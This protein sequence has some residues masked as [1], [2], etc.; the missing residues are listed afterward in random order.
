M[1]NPVSQLAQ[2]ILLAAVAAAEANKA[3]IITK[4]QGVEGPLVDALF[5]DVEKTIPQTGIFG[6]FGKEIT[7]AIEAEKANVKA[8][9]ASGDSTVFDLLAA[10]ITKFA[11]SLPGLSGG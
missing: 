5:A 2:K 7:G 1:A 6:L 8:Q 11:D 4:A 3:E 9:I 10:E